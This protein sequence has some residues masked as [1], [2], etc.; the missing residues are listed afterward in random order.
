MQ[1]IDFR[2]I[3]NFELAYAERL[4]DLIKLHAEDRKIIV[5]HV[6]GIVIECLL[7]SILVRQHQI[8]KEYYRNWYNNEAVNGVETSLVEND[9]SRRKKSEIRQHIFSYGVCINPEHKIEEA[10]NKISFLYDLYADD[11]QIRSYVQVI[12]DPLNVGSFIDLRY[13]VQSEHLN[14]EEVFLNWNQAFQFLHNWVLTNRSH[15]EVE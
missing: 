15:M 9:F 13:C 7:K 10:I 4:K 8:T 11:E 5:M 6:G 1:Q 3:E 14:I 2:E 12:Q